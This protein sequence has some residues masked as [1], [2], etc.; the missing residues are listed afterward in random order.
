M[1]DMKQIK[2]ETSLEEETPKSPDSHQENSASENVLIPKIE[3]DKPLEEPTSFKN[4][5][6]KSF[7]FLKGERNKKVLLGIGIFLLVLFISIGIPSIFI[8]RRAMAFYSQGQKLVAVGQGQSLVEIKSELS[9][10]RESF[11]KLQSSFRL[12]VWTRYIP[13]LGGYTADAQHA[14]SALSYGFDSAEVLITTVEPYADLL[15]FSDGEV[16]EAG[17]GEKTAQERM[18]FIVSAIPSLIPQIDNLSEKV[19]L[20][21]KEVDQINPARYPDNWG[22]R[23][24]RE[25]IRKGIELV[26]IAEKFVK[27]GKPLLES[28]PYILGVDSERRYLVLFQ[29]DK[30]LRPTGGFMTAYSIMKVNEARFEPTISNDIYALDARYNTTLP[31]PLPIISYIKGPY[32]LDKDLRLRDMNW[33]PDFAVSME[34]FMQEAEKA[35]INDVDGVIA[36]DTQLLAYLLD[37][38]GPIGVP[39]FGNFSTEVEPECNCPQVIYELESFADV[40]GPIVWDPISGEIIYRPPHSDNRKEIIGPLMNSIL[41]NALGQPKEKLP[42]LFGAAFK[43]LTEKHVLFYLFDDKA[44]SAVESFG[45]AGRIEGYGGDY[46]HIND[47][48]LGGRKSNLYVRQEV[49]QE[50]EVAKDG[51]VTKTLTIT[52][53]N[54]EAHDGWLNSVLP[55]WVRIYVPK[56][57]ELIDISGLEDKEDSYEEFGKTVFAGFFELRPQGV[58]KVV[59]TYK[60]PFKMKENYNLLIQKQPGKDMPLYSI[61][62]GKFEDE[63]FLK[64]DKEIKFNI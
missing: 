30:E 45:I 47:S 46:L 62:S 50:I 64:T 12:I 17:N 63:F 16:Q 19:S 1:A 13:F 34:T 61:S 31:A 21:K 29:N 56:G 49:N 22:G 7:S 44:Q 5:F 4:R 57:S 6:K 51:S 11:N 48:N 35:G 26:A 41:A 8:V 25:R 53:K 40:E 38:I 27:D 39:G 23:P 54:P 37:V 14:L 60:L 43:S 36:V 10:T 18:D 55:N 24:L 42:D 15:G 3:P 28:A 58:A 9:N 33:S 52:Y 59:V 32:I 20:A 2:P